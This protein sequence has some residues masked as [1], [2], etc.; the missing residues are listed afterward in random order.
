[1]GKR[2]KPVI[3]RINKSYYEYYYKKY[4]RLLKY[5]ANIK[6]N[7]YDDN[8]SIC[9]YEL[10]YALC[11]YDKKRST[12]NTYLT[13]RLRYKVMNFNNKEK[14]KK[15]REPSLGNRKKLIDD[16][17]YNELYVNELL[18]LVSDEEKIILVKYYLESYT[19]QEISDQ[20]KIS[21]MDVFLIKRRSIAKIKGLVLIDSVV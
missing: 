12:F 5:I 10:L 21:L 8:F 3:K 15:D 19:L 9:S 13:H 1:M 6:T 16:S 17:F 7:S 14:L 20:L 2:I 4:E 18:E 11:H